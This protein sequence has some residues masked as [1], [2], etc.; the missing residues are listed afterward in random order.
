MS[1]EYIDL[2]HSPND[3]NTPFCAFI[4][5]EGKVVG[6]SSHQG[7]EQAA[8]WCKYQALPVVAASADLRAELH[9]YGVEAYAPASGLR[10]RPKPS[11]VQIRLSGTPSDVEVVCQ[12]LKMW[13]PAH[14]HIHMHPPRT[15]RQSDGNGVIAFGMITVHGEQ[16]EQGSSETEAA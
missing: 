11:L 9:L 1:E 5:R 3:N 4:W 6:T 2:F 14:L 10:H 12:A 15:A 16:P 8:A 7:I 13:H